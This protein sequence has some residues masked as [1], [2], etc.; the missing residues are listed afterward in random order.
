MKRFRILPYSPLSNSARLLAERLEG[1]RI[2][3]QGSQYQY[4]EGDVVIN[5][6]V[7]NPSDIID[8]I[9][10]HM[11]CPDSADI[12]NWM[13]HTMNKAS[14]KLEYFKHHESQYYLP[15]FWTNPEEI[16]DNAFPV[17]CRTKLTGHSGDGIVISD[18]RDDLVSCQLYVKYI[19]KKEEYRVHLGL[20]KQGE[21]IT[22]A[23][24][25]KKRRL[26]HENPDWKVRNHANGFVYAREGVN[27]PVGVLDAAHDCFLRSGLDFGAFDVIWN[28]K[29]QKAYVLEVNT[30]PGLEGQTLDDYVNY[31]KLYA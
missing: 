24:Q 26:N 16:P 3:L 28:D 19:P 22:I 21:V 8:K 7:S 1:K 13:K 4:N 29:E 31:F 17:V 25:Q 6:G 30:A 14:N 20:N 23:V 11:Q 2:K 27:P 18:K 5:W 15:E 12:L 9:T 10:R